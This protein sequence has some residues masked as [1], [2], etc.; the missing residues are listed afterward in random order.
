[1]A[2]RR[3]IEA[4]A[5]RPMAFFPHDANASQDIK[6]EMLLEDLGME[7]YGRWWRLCE[8]LAAADGHRIEVGNERVARIVARNL[9]L[10]DV[11]ALMRF[12]AE[13][14]EL[15]LLEM[16]GDGFISSRRMDRNAEYF[17]KKRAAGRKG[18]KAKGGANVEN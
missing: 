4:A 13:L 17:G 8:L 2:T 15:A 11:D 16:G 5:S 3:E 14:K 10:G 1:M 7:G 18:G 12:L 9:M 6:I